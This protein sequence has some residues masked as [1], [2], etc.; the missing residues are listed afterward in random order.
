MARTTS[1]SS[2]TCLRL[3]QVNLATDNHAVTFE[4]A[5]HRKSDDC[6]RLETIAG[7]GVLGA[8]VIVAARPDASMFRARRE[9]AAW[10][11]MVSREEFIAASSL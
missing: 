6:T 10:I 5:Q 3:R 1:R 9:F 2:S 4:T 7:I 8:S 11:G